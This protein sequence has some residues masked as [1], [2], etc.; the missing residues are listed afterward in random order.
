[1]AS[2][3]WRSRRAPSAALAM[4]I[5][6]EP[7][8]GAPSEQALRERVSATRGRAPLP[9][10]S[11]L[12]LVSDRHGVD[13]A[14]ARARAGFSRGH[15]L[16]VVL[17]LPGGRGSAAEHAAAEQLIEAVLGEARASDWIG[18][19]TVVAAPRG[20]MLKVVQPRPESERFFPLAELSRAI[21]A[22]IS[23]LHAGLPSEPLWATGGEQ[24]W[25]LFELDVDAGPDYPRQADVALVCTF[26]PE[27]LKCF[28]SGA[29]FASARFF[30]TG[31]L[32]AYLKYPSAELDPRRALAKRRVLE[33]ALDAALVSER[34]GR[35]VGSGMGVVHS[36]V[37]LALDRVERSVAVIREVCRRVGTGAGTVLEFCDEALD[38][39][40]VEMR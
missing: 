36:Y 5:D 19:V 23:G 35:V 3:A 33:D 25:F 32:V 31:E 8:A 9:L 20:G 26:M 16:D 17:E 22:A 15:L 4:R 21:A 7:M 6:A 12:A 14:G 11:A 28:L 1:M 10:T 29:S 2:A 39:E 40:R 37:D 24:R 27:M 34:S 30:R 13:L 38:G 18:D